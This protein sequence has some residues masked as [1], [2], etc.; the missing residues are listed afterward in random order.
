MTTFRPRTRTLLAVTAVAAAAF[1]LAACVPEPSATTATPT[2]S[3]SSSATSTPAE[4]PEPSAPASDRPQ[5]LEISL[6]GSCDALYSDAMRATL[7]ADV[8][9]LNDS[10]VTFASTR[11][12]AAGGLI[13]SGVPTLH[14]TWGTGGA[15]SLSTT[16]TILASEDVPR[17]QDLLATNGLPCT[18]V[19]GGILCSSAAAGS[20]SAAEGEAHFLRGNGWVSTAWVGLP[21]QGYTEDIAATLWG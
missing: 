11:I 10:A 21:P 4:T 16:V 3:P 5:A 19:D 1:A 12:E 17:V 8:P 2:S 9:P 7:D 15:S 13:D 14:C 6:P 18:D 20:Q